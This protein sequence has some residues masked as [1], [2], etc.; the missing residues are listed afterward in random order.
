MSVV[1]S[2]IGWIDIGGKERG[3]DSR[4]EEGKSWWD[5]RGGSL[6]EFTF[7]RP[8]LF[9]PEMYCMWGGKVWGWEIRE[10]CE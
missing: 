4:E 9:D 5:V 2:G 6:Y 1:W 8:V 7:D 10:G 3:G